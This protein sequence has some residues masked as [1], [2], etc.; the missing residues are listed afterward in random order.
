M[1][2]RGEINDIESGS[3][4]RGSRYLYLYT[5]EHIHRSMHRLF[6]GSRKGKVQHRDLYRHVIFRLL[7]AAAA[8]SAEQLSNITERIA[9]PR[10]L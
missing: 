1:S 6:R 3:V 8:A 5:L 4:V 9:V 10:E 7:A 2:N